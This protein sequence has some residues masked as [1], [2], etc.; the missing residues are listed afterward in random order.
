MFPSGARPQPDSRPGN[1]CCLN[2]N[3]AAGFTLIELLVV[4]GIIA[5]LA[6]LLLSA[7]AAA[8]AQAWK[9]NCV[10]NEKQLIVAWTMYPNDN[11]ERLALNGGDD[12]TSSTS[13]HLWVHGGNHGSPDTLTNRLYLVGANFA[14]FAPLLPGEAI[15][16][17]PADRSLWPVWSG[18]AS[19]RLFPEIRSYSMNCY[20]GTPNSFPPASVD[21][22]YKI[23]LKTAQLNTD[24]PANR[25]VFTDV[26]PANI[27]TP[28]FGVD[29]SLRKWIHYP[30]YLHRQRNVMVFADG[31]M[32]THRWL[33]SLTMPHLASG[34][35]IGHDN[36]AVGDRDLKW[37]ADH[38]TSIH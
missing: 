5:T 2:R 32:E 16:K 14:L 27:C 31:H 3:F 8:K 13:P 33:N 4:I 20:I 19:A 11:N 21:P 37:I 24:S 7:L 36:S 38:T 10:S 29:M 23:Y 35:Y 28:A 30:S 18:S 1:L 9:I 26:N 22:A 12:S 25:F 34:N 6:A 17:C 15:Y